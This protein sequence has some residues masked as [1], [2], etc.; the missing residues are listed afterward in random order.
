[1]V[2]SSSYGRSRSPKPE[3]E[4]RATTEAM[5]PGGAARRRCFRARRWMMWRKTPNMPVV[6]RIKA[7]KCAGS[8]LGIE[9]LFRKGMCTKE[10]E[11]HTTFTRGPRETTV[12]LRVW[13]WSMK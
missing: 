4:V 8:S 12:A 10:M 13:F 1:M 3:R 5:L 7:R 2:S 6:A 11:T 9:F